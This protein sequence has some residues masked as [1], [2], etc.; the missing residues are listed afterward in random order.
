MVFGNVY[1]DG[2]FSPIERVSASVDLRDLV[3]KLKIE[4]IIVPSAST[5]IFE[6][7]LNFFKPNYKVPE[8]YGV[9]DIWEALEEAFPEAKGVFSGDGSGGA[10]K[11]KRSEEGT[12]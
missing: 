1:F 7:A 6:E 5:G 3:T 8:V 2:T 11:R 9:N 4:H 10:G 12:E